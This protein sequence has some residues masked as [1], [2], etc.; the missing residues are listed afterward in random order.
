M[1]QAGSRLVIGNT[2]R[3]LLEELF[4]IQNNSDNQL[5]SIIHF[6]CLDAM[7]GGGQITN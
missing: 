2:L 5:Y 4:L 7:V 6:C 3:G 1:T